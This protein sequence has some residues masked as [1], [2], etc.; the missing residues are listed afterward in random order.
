MYKTTIK[1]KKR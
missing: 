1:S